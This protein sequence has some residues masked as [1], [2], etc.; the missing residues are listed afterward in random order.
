M[1]GKTITMPLQEYKEMKDRIND[2]VGK[3]MS[4]KSD[5]IHIKCSR[6]YGPYREWSC[7]NPDE[8][9]KSMREALLDKEQELEEKKGRMK[10]HFEHKKNMLGRNLI[11]ATEESA[12]EKIELRESLGWYKKAFFVSASALFIMVIATLIMIAP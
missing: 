11:R 4:M 7:V 8:A 9:M 10:E 1:D 2:L 6:L 3:N 5:E 12:L